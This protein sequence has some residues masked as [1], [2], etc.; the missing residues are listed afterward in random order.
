MTVRLFPDVDGC[1]NALYPEDAWDD[2]RVVP[3]PGAIGNEIIFSPTMI[4]RINALNMEVHWC[5]AWLDHAAIYLGPMMNFGFERPHL[6]AAN[7]IHDFP[8]IIWKR[9][10]VEKFVTENPGPFVWWDDEMRHEDI[11]WAESVG[12]LAIRCNERHGVMPY[13]VEQIEEYVAANS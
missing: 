6:R 4:S 10:C 9:E 11:R 8:T 1:L 5:T 2:Y 13:Q 7:G 3:F 12:G